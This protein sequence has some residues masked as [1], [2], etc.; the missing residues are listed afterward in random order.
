MDLCYINFHNDCKYY[1]HRVGTELLNITIS[2]KYFKSKHLC[3]FEYI[4]IGNRR[5]LKLLNEH[6]FNHDIL[7][8][9]I[10]K[11]LIEQLGSIIVDTT[12][13]RSHKQSTQFYIKNI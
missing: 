13:S 7:D 10:N 1:V 5:Y 2:N 11:F 12:K 9:V 6:H 8:S 3:M 4:N